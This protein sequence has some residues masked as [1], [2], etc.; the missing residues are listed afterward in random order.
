MTCAL[1]MIEK[2]QLVKEDIILQ[3]IREVKIQMFLSHP[4]IIKMYGCFDDQQHIYII[5]ELA[6]GGQLY[7]QLKRSEPMP[8]VKAAGFMKQVCVAVE[9]LHS[10]RIIHRD[11]KPENIVLHEVPLI[12][13]R[14]W[15]NCATS[16]GQ[17]T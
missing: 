10:S 15:S 2:A 17:S 7:E 11:I 5:L 12:V 3:F 8:E 14:A 6:M 13:F 1:K 4:N 9:Q 16:A